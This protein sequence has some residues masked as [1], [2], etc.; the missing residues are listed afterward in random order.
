MSTLFKKILSYG[1]LGLTL[2][3]LVICSIGHLLYK[4]CFSGQATRSHYI[5]LIDFLLSNRSI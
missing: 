3:I 5:E 4:L 2:A 1:Y